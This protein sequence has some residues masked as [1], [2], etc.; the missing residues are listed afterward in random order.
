MSKNEYRRV[1]IWS[2]WLR[3]CHW[4]VGLATLV[5]LL[6]GWLLAESPSLAESAL[7]VHYLAAGILLFGLMVRFALMLIGKTHERFTALIPTSSDIKGIVATLRFYL[8]LG[9]TPLPRWYAH[10]PLWK[11]LYLLSYLALLV[12][13]ASG[14]VMQDYPL[15]WGFYLPTLHAGWAQL[16]FWFSAL[17]IAAVVLHDGRGRSTDI[18]AM[19]NGLRLFSI[20]RDHLRGSEE[21]HV[22]FVSL[23]EVKRR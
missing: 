21:G 22:Q 11:L 5:L 9:R 7:D 3:L 4:S 1:L 14:A 13:L 16:L 8:S 15:V 17:H 23:D 12:Q 6:T 20:D 2:G 18:S 19:L 10:N